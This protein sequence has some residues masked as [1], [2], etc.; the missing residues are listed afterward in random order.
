MSATTWNFD[1]TTY[2]EGPKYGRLEILRV[3]TDKRLDPNVF[4]FYFG[5]T[6]D[7]EQHEHSAAIQWRDQ[8]K[9]VVGLLGWQGREWST[10]SVLYP[11]DPTHNPGIKPT[12][13]LYSQ[14]V[15]I[16]V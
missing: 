14:V 10:V 3:E 8:H 6:V 1:G 7:G 2:Y 15:M 13:W 4:T 11:G 12:G 5:L 16:R 9:L